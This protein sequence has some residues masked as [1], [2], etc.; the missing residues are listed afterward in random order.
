[1]DYEGVNQIDNIYV[2]VDVYTLAPL[3]NIVA[4]PAWIPTPRSSL[5]LRTLFHT[6]RIAEYVKSNIPSLSGIR[7][8][9]I[10]DE[11]NFV[12]FK[13]VSGFRRTRM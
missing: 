6:V 7:H 4:G 5:S 9:V 10:A 3:F 12:T 11:G 1:M 8:M 2:V 13:S